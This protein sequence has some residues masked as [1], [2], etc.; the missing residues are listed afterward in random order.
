MAECV[1]CKKKTDRL[2]RVSV[3]HVG[4]VMACQACVFDLIKR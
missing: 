2:I 3:K 4:S 1:Q